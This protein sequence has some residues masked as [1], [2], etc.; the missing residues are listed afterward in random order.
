MDQARRDLEK[1]Y[2]EYNQ[3]LFTYAVS[4]TRSPQ[5]AEDAM[6]DAF[7]RLLLLKSIP[8]NFK[9]YTFRSV[10]NAA[11]DLLR[12]KSQAVDWEDVDL[13]ATAPNPC[14][15]AVQEEFSH[16]VATALRQLSDDERE[17]IVLHLYS[18]LSFRDIAELQ[19]ISINTVMS[20]Y[21]RG[22]EKLRELL[23]T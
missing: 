13:F 10:R 19:D 6:Q 14:E 17:A 12:K 1:I 16:R 18:E 8:E 22:I 3:Q 4:I 23:E 2:D 5:M 15:N 20:W 21:R 11:I 9:L 7:C